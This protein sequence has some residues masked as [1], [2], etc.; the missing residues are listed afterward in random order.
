VCGKPICFC[1]SEMG[2]F[3]AHSLPLGY[4]ASEHFPETK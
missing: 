2:F 4:F 3:V 1:T